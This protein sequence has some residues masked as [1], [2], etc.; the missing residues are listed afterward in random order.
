MKSTSNLDI[1]DFDE[2]NM[3]LSGFIRLVGGVR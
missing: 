3:A 1:D 2:P